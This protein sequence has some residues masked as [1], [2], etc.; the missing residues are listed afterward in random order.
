MKDNILQIHNIPTAG[1]KDINTIVKRNF[2]VLYIQEIQ[3]R[4]DHEKLQQL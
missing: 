4:I 3:E 1:M 2:R